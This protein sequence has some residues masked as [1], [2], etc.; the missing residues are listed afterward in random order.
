[1][2]NGLTVA[3]TS[4]RSVTSRDTDRSRSKPAKS[5]SIKSIKIEL[6]NLHPDTNRNITPADQ[7]R[8]R[9]LTN[10]LTI[11]RQRV[12]SDSQ[13]RV[14]HRFSVVHREVLSTVLDRQKRARASLVVKNRIRRPHTLTDS[15]DCDALQVRLD[16]QQQ[17]VKNLPPA[18]GL[19][20]C[21][22]PRKNM[23]MDSTVDVSLP[24]DGIKLSTR[25]LKLN[26][27]F[28]KKVEVGD[29]IRPGSS[30]ELQNDSPGLFIVKDFPEQNLVRTQCG[31]VMSIN[32]LRNINRW[33]IDAARRLQFEWLRWVGLSRQERAPWVVIDQHFT[34]LVTSEQAKKYR[35]HLSVDRLF[36]EVEENSR[37]NLWF[38]RKDHRDTSKVCHTKFRCPWD[39]D[40]QDQ[41][42]RYNNQYK[43]QDSD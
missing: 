31:K 21:F 5:L 22:R 43:V 40:T 29:A 34:R 28:S 12:S 11:K 18:A 30:V 3:K 14:I 4:K 2:K 15:R 32:L 27:W 39:A 8:V 42:Y 17:F 1:M 25:G 7:D 38:D 23:I 36:R 6:R 41:Y 16:Q 9:E 13:P 35:R 19:A 26:L 20:S 24:S 10:A 37:A 33:P